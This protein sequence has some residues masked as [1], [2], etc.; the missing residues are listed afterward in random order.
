MFDTDPYTGIE[1]SK[2]GT[3]ILI[4]CFVLF[5]IFIFFGHKISTYFYGINFSEGIISDVFIIESG[6][7]KE[8]VLW[9]FICTKDG[10][11]IETGRS[12]SFNADNETHKI[13]PGLTDSTYYSEFFQEESSGVKFSIVKRKK[14]FIDY[15]LSN[16][17][18]EVQNIDKLY[19]IITQNLSKFRKETI[20]NT[21]IYN[22][23]TIMYFDDKDIIHF[24]YH[25]CGYK[26][27]SKALYLYE[28]LLYVDGKLQYINTLQR[29]EFFNK[30]LHNDTIIYAKRILNIYLDDTG[31]CIKTFKPIEA[32]GRGDDRDD[33]FNQLVRKLD[34][35]MPL[36]EDSC[37]YCPYDGTYGD[38][39]LEKLNWYRE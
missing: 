9:Y 14:V 7:E 13:K 37:K 17:E 19:K 32:K 6:N 25:T 36:V 1:L 35:D 10:S 22:D 29:K 23:T 2:K 34:D 16:K 20:T 4:I 5:Y 33:V 24:V 3:V 21:S 8:L 26:G 18:Q 11:I 30:K 39:Y 28:N 12:Y 15:D 31:R 27:S 38:R